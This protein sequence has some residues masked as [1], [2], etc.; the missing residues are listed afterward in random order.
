M[1]SSEAPNEYTSAVSIRLMPASSAMSMWR[2][3]PAT[4][5]SP[6]FAK[7]PCPPKVIVPNV[8]V[9]TRSPE[10][11]SCRYRIGV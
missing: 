7:L 8:S 5:V 10:R 3:A 9:D 1:I 2:R 11:P 6:T 4:S